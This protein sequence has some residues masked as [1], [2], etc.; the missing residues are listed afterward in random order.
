MT[1]VIKNSNNVDNNKIVIK[2]YN[3]SHGYVTLCSTLRKCY[4]LLYFCI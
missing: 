2:K 4:D 3:N 1:M